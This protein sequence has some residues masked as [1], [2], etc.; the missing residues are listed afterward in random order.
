MAV[1]ITMTHQCR[2]GCEIG[3]SRTRLDN[4]AADGEDDDLRV[5]TAACVEDRKCAAPGQAGDEGQW[6]ETGEPQLQRFV[7]CASA[8]GVIAPGSEADLHGDNKGDNRNLCRLT[9]E[10]GQDRSRQDRDSG[11]QM[12]DDAV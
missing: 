9:F 1:T 10:I 7:V 4:A 5:G 6:D 12:G 3:A 2:S 11:D 8:I